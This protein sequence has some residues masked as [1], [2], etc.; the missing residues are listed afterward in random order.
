[1][2]ERICQRTLAGQHQKGGPERR[3]STLQEWSVQR[4]FCKD[5]D[6]RL[7]TGRRPIRIALQRAKGSTELDEPSGYDSAY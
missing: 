7:L 5:Q 3:G 4:C 2:M 6:G 1:M